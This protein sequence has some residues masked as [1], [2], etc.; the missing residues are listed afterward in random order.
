MLSINVNKCRSQ[1][2]PKAIDCER[3]DIFLK[4]VTQ[5]HWSKNWLKSG[6][7]NMF[8]LSQIIKQ[9]IKITDY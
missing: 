7:K 4:G 9:K 2:R 6:I 8:C 5:S 3:N 1:G